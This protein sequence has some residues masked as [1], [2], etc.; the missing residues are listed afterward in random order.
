MNYRTNEDKLCAAQYNN[1][2]L[3]LNVEDL[4]EDSGPVIEPVLLQELKDYMRIEGFS[5]GAVGLALQTPVVATL[6][7]G[8]SQVTVPELMGNVIVALTREGVTYSIG[9]TIGNK[10]ATLDTATGT[11]VFNTVGEAGGETI[12]IVYGIPVGA[13]TADDFTFDD[14]LIEDLITEAREWVEKFTGIHLVPK[15]L[16]VTFCN[17]LGGFELPGPV[18]GAIDITGDLT[19]AEYVGTQFPKVSSMAN[20]LT[21]TYAA[22]Y[23]YGTVPKWAKNAIK[24]YVTWGYERRGDEAD[25]KGSPERAAAICRVHRRVALWA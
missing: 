9:V 20:S 14:T 8:L 3:L 2:N 19:T 1:Y 6:S 24:A 11:L 25:I 13:A 23:N 18:Q 22:G 10:I 21:A 16:Q 12:N 7:A 5:G 17:G 4:S 15:R